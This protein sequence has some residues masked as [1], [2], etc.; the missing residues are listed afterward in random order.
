MQW[1]TVKITSDRRGK[2]TPFASVG[3]G[4]LSLNSAACELIDDFDS[5]QY[6]ELLKGR[7]SD[8]KLCVGIRLLKENSAN[9][10]K[11]SKRIYKG[12]VTKS[13]AI[14]NKPIMEAL[15]GISGVQQKI[16]RY[17]VLKDKSANNILMII[18]I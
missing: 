2:T 7:D 10:I 14:D 4:R 17:T 18:G 13:F 5:Y 9:S 8:N 3:F 12:E 16:T 1:E 6:A 15:F 11:I